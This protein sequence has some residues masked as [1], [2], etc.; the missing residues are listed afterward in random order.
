MLSSFCGINMKEV[1]PN[2][3]SEDKEKLAKKRALQVGKQHEQRHDMGN[4]H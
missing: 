1:M 3:C 2:L 4:G